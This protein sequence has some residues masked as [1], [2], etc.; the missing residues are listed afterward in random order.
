MKQYLIGSRAL[1]EIFPNF[2]RE[3]KDF[4]YLVETKQKSYVSNGIHIEY[5]VN[6]IL[7]NY[8]S[9]HGLDKHVLLTLKISHIF[10]DIFWDKHIFDI[11][12]LYE[13]GAKLIPNLFSDLY[14][15]W[16]VVHGNNKRSDLKM[17]SDSFFDNDM[18]TYDHDMLHTYINTNPTYFKVLKDNAEVEVDEN[19]FNLL[20]FEE[21]LDLAKEEIYVMAFERLNKRSYR[22]AYTWML[23]KFIINHAPI[24][25]ALFLIENYRKIHLPEFDFIKKIN[26]ELIKNNYSAVK[27][28]KNELQRN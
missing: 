15:Y 21:K 6:P 4:D 13:N 14:K 27:N 5:H 12:F 2:K 24:Y 17:T 20:S 7:F 1:K 25:E 10:W 26:E 19:K 22:T 23:K 3:P 28:K 9:E 11:V 18:N 8:I 16:S